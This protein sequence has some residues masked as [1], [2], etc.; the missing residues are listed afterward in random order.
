MKRTLGTA[1]AALASLLTSCSPEPPV[2][3]PPKP[4]LTAPSLSPQTSTTSAATDAQPSTTTEPAGTGTPTALPR[5][6]VVDGF[7]TVRYDCNWPGPG[8]SSTGREAKA[9]QEAW[10]KERR[11]PGAIGPG[12]NDRYIFWDLHGASVTQLLK[13]WGEPDHAP[14]RLKAQFTGARSIRIWVTV[15]RPSP[16]DL[17]ARASNSAAGMVRES[18][19]MRLGEKAPVAGTCTFHPGGRPLPPQAKSL[20]DDTAGWRG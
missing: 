7:L 19:T 15:V 14:P 17:V 3:K 4:A 9:P 6:S 13:T 12:R 16:T 18:M 2:T 8:V 5:L 10:A 11:K 1:V 20:V